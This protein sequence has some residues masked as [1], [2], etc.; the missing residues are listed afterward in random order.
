MGFFGSF[1]GSD[2]RRDINKANKQ[3]TQNLQQGYNT[4]NQ[5]YDQAYD[6]Y[7]PYVQQGT[8]ANT[9]YNNALGINGANAQQQA[10]NTITGNPLFQNS[11]NQ[12]NNQMMRYLN[13]RGNSGG[14]ADLA[15]QRVFQQNIGNWLDRYND[16][17]QRGLTATTLGANVRTGQGDNAMGYGATRANQSINYGNAMASSRNIG[18]NNLMNLGGMIASAATGIP[19]PKFG[20]TTQPGTSANMG[21]ETTTTPTF[22]NW[23]GNLFGGGR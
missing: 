6:M 15:A 18:I 10:Y 21:W 22:G 4:Q 1:F 23:L 12:D 19:M 16:A 9:M 11:L 8:E 3:A 5:R 20:Q 14:A 7:N 2:Q 13:A 17:G